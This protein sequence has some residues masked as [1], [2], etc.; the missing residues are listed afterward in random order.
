[1][2]FCSKLS[3]KRLQGWGDSTESPTTQRLKFSLQKRL[4]FSLE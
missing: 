2:K 4:Q 3:C 1:M